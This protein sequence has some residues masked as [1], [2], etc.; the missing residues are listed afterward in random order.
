MRF[1]VMRMQPF[2]HLFALDGM[3]SAAASRVTPPTLPRR[4]FRT[5]ADVNWHK[6]EKASPMKSGMRVPAQEPCWSA[7]S[8]TDTLIRMKR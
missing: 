4:I 3:L 5:R 1:A 2:P 7:S 8:G 6:N